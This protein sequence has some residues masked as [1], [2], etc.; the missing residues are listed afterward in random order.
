MAARKFENTQEVLRA[1]PPEKVL[2]D[3]EG[4]R[5]SVRDYFEQAKVLIRSDGGRG[6]PRWFSPLECGARMPNS[7]LLLYLPGKSVPPPSSSSFERN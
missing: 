3:D 4:E 6:P 7:P 5:M 2:E 1:A